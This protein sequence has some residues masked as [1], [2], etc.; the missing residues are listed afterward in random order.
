MRADRRD[1]ILAA[2][3]PLLD[4]YPGALAWFLLGSAAGDALRSD[5][6]VDLAVLPLDGHQF[7]PT[8]LVRL[9][10][11]LSLVLGREV[12]LGVLDSSNLV[13]AKEALLSGILITSRDA[14][15]VL[16]QKARLLALYLTFQEDRKEVLD[17]YRAG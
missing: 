6:D 15:L 11:E 16:G 14:A 13:Y 8:A 7:D 12:D 9:S 4:D 5:S 2:L 10:G 3:I 1:E 17:A